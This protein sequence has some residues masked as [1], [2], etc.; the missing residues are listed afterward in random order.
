MSEPDRI[1]LTA[2]T[3]AKLDELLNE[4]NPKKDEKGISLIK[5]DLYRLAVA[6]GIKKGI[7]PPPLNDRSVPSFRVSELDKDGVL[8][9]VLINSEMNFSGD[10]VYG[11]IERIAENEIKFFYEENQRTGQIPYS[12]I[13]ST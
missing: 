4:L 11:Y 3:S 7:E 6:I 5:F 9:T 12:E 10:S 8:Y 2:E 1:G 13:F